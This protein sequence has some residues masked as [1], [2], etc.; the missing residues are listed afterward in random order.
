MVIYWP[1]K[2]PKLQQSGDVVVARLE[3]DVTVKRLET[4]GDQCRL[5][6]ENPA[7]AP[8]EVRPGDDFFIEGHAV[9][10]IR[11]DL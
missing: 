9:G 6:A 3:G 2:S 7:Y 1:L 5:I 4:T 8:I 11:T 10:V